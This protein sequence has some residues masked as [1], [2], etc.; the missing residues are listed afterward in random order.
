MR[1][2]ITGAGGNVA[3]GVVERLRRSGHELVLTDVN[4]LPDVETFADLEFH[5]LDIQIGVGLEK[6]AEGCD[7]LLHTP[8]WHG[9]HSRT[10]TE[11]D[12]W[13][14]NVDGTFWAL[15]AAESA[16]ISRL[17]FLSSMSWFGHYEK[18][19]FTKRVGEE[20]C[21]YHR[22]AH[23]LRYVSIRPH[24]FTPWGDDWLN[25][26]GGRL[27]RGGVD[28]AD[29]LDC[30]DAAVRTLAGDAPQDEPEGAVVHAVRANAFTED[31][32]ADWET[33]PLGTAEAIFPGS[34]ALITKYGIDISARPSVLE[35][36]G[37]ASIGYAPTRHFGTF[38]AELAEL[39][40]TDPAAVGRMHC[41]Y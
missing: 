20:L 35:H 4:R 33:D 25:R 36:V 23:G 8:A 7:L 27:L 24:D 38:L 28:R 13:R 10:K 12:F 40:A 6:A 19:G 30:V 9:I 17:V 31:Q 26:Y 2:L 22:Q 14:L 37:A 3:T 16:G 34:S 15:Q 18:Y 21:E 41:P 39:D 11:V 5:Q 32:V 1:I 29:V